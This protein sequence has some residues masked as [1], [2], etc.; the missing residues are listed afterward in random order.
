MVT[1]LLLWLPL[2]G[3]LRKLIANQNSFNIVAMVAL[4]G[5]FVAWVWWWGRRVYQQPHL[6]RNY[7]LKGSRQN[8]L[9]LLQGLGL[10]LSS[11]GGLFLLE[12]GLGWLE[13]QPISGTIVRIALEGCLV[14][15]GVGFAEELF[16]RGWLLD[17]LQRDYTLRKAVVIDSLVFALLHFL[18]PLS[19][20]YRTWPQFPGLLLLGLT[21]AWAKVGTLERRRPGSGRLG[22]P[23]GLHAGLVWGYYI[24]NVGGLIEYSQQVPEWVTGIDR[25]PL[26]G[27]AG[28]LLL[29][30]LAL[31]MRVRVKRRNA[32]AI[33]K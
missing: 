5:L 28:L 12:G 11:L 4:Y 6:L 24:I 23:V 21:L 30:L 18:K 16:F 29:G 8:G 9:E 10:G 2:V 7:G 19:E 17:E 27:A 31:G 26:A 3:V 33:L 22:L 20:I 25:N 1:L 14:A 32:I 15:L 13:W